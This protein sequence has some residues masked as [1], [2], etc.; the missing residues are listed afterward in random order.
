MSWFNAS[1]ILPHI[2]RI[3]FCGS[4]CDAVMRGDPL[5]SLGSALLTA[6]CQYLAYREQKHTHSHTVGGR[7]WGWD[8]SRSL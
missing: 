1:Q 2:Y 5:R 6:V 8:V 3:I 7:E 4:S